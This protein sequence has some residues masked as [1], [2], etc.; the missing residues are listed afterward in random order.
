MFKELHVLLSIKFFAANAK[1][2]TK[3]SSKLNPFKYLWVNLL[4]IFDNAAAQ[5]NSG[6]H[7]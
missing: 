7:V 1:N 3:H 2:L 6:G 4:S 5:F